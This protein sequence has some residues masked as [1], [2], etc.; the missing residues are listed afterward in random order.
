MPSS[1]ST[2][3]GKYRVESVPDVAEQQLQQWHELLSNWRPGKALPN[4]Q[5]LNNGGAVFRIDSPLGPLVVKRSFD[6]GIKGLLSICRIRTPVLLRAFRL[7][8]RALAAGLHTARPYCCFIRRCSFGFETVLITEFLDGTSPWRLT[9]MEESGLT[10][11]LS[12]LGREIA[13][14]HANGLRNRD[15]KGPNLIYN[16]DTQILNFIDLDGTHERL[17]VP[18]LHLRARD[19]SRCKAG[20]LRAG[21]TEKQWQVTQNAYLSRCREQQITINDTASFDAS[22]NDGVRKKVERYLKKRGE[23]REARTQ[24]QSDCCED[25]TSNTGGH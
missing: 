16:P 24:S 6:I 2:T 5:R 9:E 1:I 25:E 22:I 10:L 12:R 21:L 14:W 23:R 15:L 17:P 18:S 11:M 20:A 8:T 19:L 7:G 4:A 3:I 13:D